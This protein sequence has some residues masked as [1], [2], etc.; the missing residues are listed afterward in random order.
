M[1]PARGRQADH[2]CKKQGRRQAGRGVGARGGLRPGTGRAHPPSGR[3]PRR[4]ARA[5][6]RPEALAAMPAICKRRPPT[7]RVWPL[8]DQTVDLIALPRASRDGEEEGGG[9]RGGE[10]G[11]V[12]SS[13]GAGSGKS[14]RT[15]RPAQRRP[16]QVTRPGENNAAFA[17]HCAKTY[18][19]QNKKHPGPKASS[20][21]SP[22]LMVA[23]R[24]ARLDASSNSGRH[25]ENEAEI[26]RVFQRATRYRLDESE[27]AKLILT[28]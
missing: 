21:I 10:G 17:I 22:Q 9:G 27:G 19:K 25:P 28:L 5:G 4:P 15:W 14:W 6:A 23:C 24:G 18:F 13:K 12:G 16:R 7:R 26:P 11:R 20:Q 1:M 8:G 2:S 3:P